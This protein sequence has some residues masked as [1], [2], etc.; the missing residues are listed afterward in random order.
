MDAQNKVY[1]LILDAETQEI[2]GVMDVP[3]DRLTLKQGDVVKVMDEEGGTGYFRIDDFAKFSTLSE[4]ASES[5]DGD[6]FIT[7]LVK[8]QNADLITL[9]YPVYNVYVFLLEP[10]DSIREENGEVQF[11]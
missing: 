4:A 5:A 7:N 1:G 6:E 2:L 3:E 10:E 9:V 11:P 8:A